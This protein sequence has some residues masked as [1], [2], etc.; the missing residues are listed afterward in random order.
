[1]K[2]ISL[3]QKLQ[4]LSMEDLRSR[5]ESARKDLFGLRVNT[6]ATPVKDFS[7]YKKLRKDIARILT[8][9]RAR[10]DKMSVVNQS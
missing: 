6:V 8:A 5:L 7:Q 2:N 9:M 4:Q 3:F 1:M 10:E